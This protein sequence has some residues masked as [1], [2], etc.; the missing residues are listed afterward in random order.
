MRFIYSKGATPLSP[1]EIH[2]LIPS[3]LTV[4]KELDEWEQ[5]NILK[6]EN[7]LSGKKNLDILNI[8]FIQ[9]LHYRMFKDTWKW[10]GKYRKTQT[11]IGVDSIY[12]AQELGILLD[13]VK[14]WI[15]NKTYGLREIGIRLH[16]RMVYIH[17][18]INGNGRFTRLIADLFI[19][20]K[21]EKCY[22]W[23][24]C[25]LTNDSDIRQKYLDALKMADKGEYDKLIKFADS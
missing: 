2:N 6:A 4:Q 18:F 21:G 8:K 23:G 3:H 11:N 12:I 7:W 25:N 15:E 16:H 19:R 17:P 24:K 14:F 5:Y 13:D 20:S 10:A 1:D 9:N 22:S